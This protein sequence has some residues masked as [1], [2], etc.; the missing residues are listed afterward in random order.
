[1]LMKV[2]KKIT[3]ENNVKNWTKAIIIEQKRGYLGKN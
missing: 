1:M 2:L 3:H